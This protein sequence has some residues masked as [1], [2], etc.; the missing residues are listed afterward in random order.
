MREDK[1]AAVKAVL[2]KAEK[3]AL[4]A[5]CRGANATG[6][7]MAYSLPPVILPSSALQ[8]QLRNRLNSTLATRYAPVPTCG[9]PNYPPILVQQVAGSAMAPLKSK[10]H[11]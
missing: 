2:K 5:S 8:K 6:S 3:W 9:L 11:V 1:D 7:I 10:N 4:A